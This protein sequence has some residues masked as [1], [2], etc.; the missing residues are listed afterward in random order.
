MAIFREIS[1]KIKSAISPKSSPSP[2]ASHAPAAA[3]SFEVVSGHKSA[4]TPVKQIQ[5]RY[6]RNDSF[7]TSATNLSRES[8]SKM[9]FSGESMSTDMKYRRMSKFKEELDFGEVYP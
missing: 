9:S 8:V 2:V 5:Q 3:S 4:E 7:M 1:K 6:T